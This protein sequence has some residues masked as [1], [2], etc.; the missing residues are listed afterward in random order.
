VRVWLRWRSVEG[1]RM[2]RQQQQQQRVW[3]NSLQG[4]I[5]S[6][7]LSY[8]ELPRGFGFLGGSVFH[9]IQRRPPTP[10]PPADR[11][12]LEER[13]G[14]QIHKDFSRLPHSA[15]H[16]WQKARARASKAK[17]KLGAGGGRAS[18]SSSSS[19][20][21]PPP[22][23]RELKRV[24]AEFAEAWREVEA[25]NAVAVAELAGTHNFL[26]R[27][28]LVMARL[29]AA[30]LQERAVVKEG[31]CGGASAV[32]AYKEASRLPHT[33]HSRRRRPPRHHRRRCEDTNRPCRGHCGRRDCCQES[34]GGC[35]EGG[36][37]CMFCGS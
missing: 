6:L 22:L 12:T 3:A 4:K 23:G 37:G 30:P 20:S 10:R 9:T 17:K 8:S 27:E 1:E 24:E 13:E 5:V 19:S 31:P 16:A 25:A 26:A 35:S 28:R 32:A 7:V 2:Q 34:R 36:R 15:R 18:S 29:K 21:P 14:T 11:R 33:P